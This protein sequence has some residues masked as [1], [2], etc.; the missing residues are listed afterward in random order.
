VDGRPLLG[1]RDMVM[2]RTESGRPFSPEE[3]ISVEGAMVA[4]TR[5]SAFA[6]RSEHERG[7]IEAGKLADLVVLGEDPRLVRPEDIGEVPVIATIV[8]GVV[9][10]RAG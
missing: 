3:A 9:A 6:T 8:G 4:Y 2:R 7:S 1:I 5:G 10:Y